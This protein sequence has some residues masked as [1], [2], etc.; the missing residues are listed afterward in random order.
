M[1]NLG[2]DFGNPGDDFPDDFFDSGSSFYLEDFQDFSVPLSQKSFNDFSINTES[3]VTIT[4]IDSGQSNDTSQFQYK[5][6]IFS[7]P[8][9]SNL[10]NDQSHTSISQPLSNNKFIDFF[11]SSLDNHQPFGDTT[12]S[13]KRKVD[14]SHNEL[15]F[16][17]RFYAIFTTKKKFEKKLVK[18]I[19][20]YIRKP[21]GFERMSREEFRRIDIYF[22]NYAK[23]SPQILSYLILHKE[24]IFDKF[25]SK[26]FNNI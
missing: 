14:L 5:N 13:P 9:D 8:I 1:V 2:E 10:S 26:S 21:F 3:N 25:L 15:S 6:S 11:D 22:R 18:Q 17:D 4:P 20:D 12:R 24:E 16:K 23:Y 7:I 19:H